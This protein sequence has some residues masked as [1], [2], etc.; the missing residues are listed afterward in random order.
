MIYSK[1]I[2]NKSIAFYLLINQICDRSIKNRPVL[3]GLPPTEWR[4]NKNFTLWRNRHGDVDLQ[5]AQDEGTEQLKPEDKMTVTPWGQSR[6]GDSHALGTAGQ[7]FDI[8]I[9]HC[10][11]PWKTTIA[12]IIYYAYNDILLLHM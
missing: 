1:Q 8:Y 5:S 4:I 2:K 7:R 11:L 6:L 3:L 12:F 9:A 10:G